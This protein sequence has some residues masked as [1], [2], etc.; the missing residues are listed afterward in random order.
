MRFSAILAATVALLAIPVLGSPAGTLIDIKKHNGEIKEGSYIVT[1]KSNISKTTHLKWLSQHIDKDN[2]THPGWDRRILNG[3]AGTFSTKTLNMLRS[4][5]DVESISEDGIM[6]I[7]AT[8]KDAP[9]GLARISRDKKLANQ[10]PNALNFTY[11]YPTNAGSGV[12]IYIIDTG[13]FTGHSDFGG[14][15]RW[16]AT[17]GGY[18][19]ADGNGHG[20]HVAG[21]AA[22]TR[23]GVAKSANLIAVKVLSDRACVIPD[24]GSSVSQ[25][26]YPTVID[27]NADG[28]A[29]QTWPEF[30]HVRISGMNFVLTSATTSG[31]PSIASM[32]LGGIVADAIDDA[33]AALTNAGIHVT[34]SAGN[35]DVDAANQSPARAPSAVT[36]G[37][38]TIAD[39]K[40]EI[41][42]YG[43]VVDI[44]APGENIISA[45]IGSETAMHNISGTSMATPHVAG[46]IASYISSVGN[47]SPAEMSAFVKD[48]SIKG[49]ISGIPSGTINA[50]ARQLRT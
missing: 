11:K 9:W 44:W 15:A 23:F 42:N 8:Q 25:Y 46:L 22:G 14:R 32:S 43:A 34:V 28:I 24:A 48:Q 21:T 30:G 4:S 18:K 5:P 35:N 50:L 20:T 12:D 13:I 41:S 1:L 33:V 37:A 19:D 26:L 3:F 49:A 39:A 27:G 6:T 47:K 40:A 38:T 31:R 36:V 17:F 7:Q 29:L 16:G 45:W 10:D 2:I